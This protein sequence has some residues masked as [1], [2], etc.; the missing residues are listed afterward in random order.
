MFFLTAIPFGVCYHEKH[1][2]S[3]NYCP[4]SHFGG[5]W[6]FSAKC[7]PNVFHNITRPL[8]FMFWSES[9]LLDVV[10]FYNQHPK[11]LKC[12]QPGRGGRTK[13]V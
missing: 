1:L 10:E 8:A 5:H 11:R 13:V 3:F 7:G 2:E 9:L 4:Q 12:Y 6:T